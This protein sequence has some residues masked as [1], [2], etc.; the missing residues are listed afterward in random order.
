MLFT[1]A[2][3]APLAYNT[4]GAR[5]YLHVSSFN[6]NTLCRYMN[7]PFCTD[8]SGSNAYASG[9]LERFVHSLT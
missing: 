1:E 3:S 7:E 8:S 5:S 4:A 2:A 6:R 9:N